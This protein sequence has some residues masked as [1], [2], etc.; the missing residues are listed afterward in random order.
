MDVHGAASIHNLA[1]GWLDNGL[2][3]EQII[4]ELH[5]HGVDERHIPD[6]L[7]EIKKLRNARKTSNGLI[8]IL[9]GAVTCLLSC[10][11]TMTSSYSHTAFEIVL[12]GFTTIGILVVVWGLM[13]IFN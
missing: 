5:K 8:L 7:A 6:M 13:K 9:I 4:D 10:V 11:L 12:Y 1:K 3:N 2:S